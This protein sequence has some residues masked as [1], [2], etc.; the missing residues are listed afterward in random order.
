MTLQRSTSKI[1][2]SFWRKDKRRKNVWDR[3]QNPPEDQKQK[4]LDYMEKYYL[5]HK[6]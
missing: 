3:Y 1:P 4:P 5:A 6:K 2:K